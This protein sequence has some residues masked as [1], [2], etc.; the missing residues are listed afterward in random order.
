MSEFK[1]NL[2]DKVKDNITGYTGVVICQSCWI[3]G[4]NTYGVRSQELKDG[5]P[6]EAQFMDEPQLEV[7]E[8]KILPEHRKTGGPCVSVPSPNRV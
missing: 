7:V 6:Q 1:F 3:N 4:C 2:G 5:L 8:E